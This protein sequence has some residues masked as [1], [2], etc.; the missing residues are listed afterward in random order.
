AIEV[1]DDADANAAGAQV[2]ID[3]KPVGKVPVN[4]PV[5][6][7][8]VLVEVKKTGFTDFAQWADVKPGDR[9]SL[10]PQLAAR[11]QKGGLLIDAAVPGAKISVDGKDIPDTT[12][13]FVDNLDAGPHVVEVRKPPGPPW[14]GTVEVKANTHV[15]VVGELAKSSG[16]S[17]RVMSNR[18]DAE[19]WV[20]GDGKGRAPVDIALVPVGPHGVEVRAPGVKPRQGKVNVQGG[21]GEVGQRAP[22]DQALAGPGGRLRVISPAPGAEV[23]IDGA[24]VGNAPF[25]GE[26]VAGPHYVLVSKLGF[27]KFERQVTIEEGKT[28]TVTAELKA[29][30]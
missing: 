3:G 6:A 22:Q 30:G 5:P 12:P 27:G 10:S 18:D 8:R 13:A 4:V 1:R 15:K 14:K 24:P 28:A 20:D 26:I 16:G 21:R 25:E 9:I 29:A 19:V 17:L 7:G 23:S 11:A 2:L